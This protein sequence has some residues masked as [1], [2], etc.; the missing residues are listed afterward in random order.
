MEYSE[1]VPSKFQVIT[2]IFTEIF[3]DVVRILSRTHSIGIDFR[4]YV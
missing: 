2:I 4:T 3:E 1:S